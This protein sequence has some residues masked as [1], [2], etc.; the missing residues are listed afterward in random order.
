MA[1]AP[2]AV[3]AKASAEEIVLKWAQTLVPRNAPK[4]AVRGPLSWVR[5]TKVAELLAE[6][7]KAGVK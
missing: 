7:K 6:L 5:G 1:Q 4:I 3:A 2:Q